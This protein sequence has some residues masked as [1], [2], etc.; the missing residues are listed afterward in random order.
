MI[1]NPA[2]TRLELSDRISI[3]AVAAALLVP[4]LVQ[5]WAA[6]AC[7]NIDINIRLFGN[8]D[9]EA[10]LV[11]SSPGANNALNLSFQ[12]GL[13]VLSAYINLTG[14]PYTAGGTDCPD[15]PSLDLGNDGSVEWR[16]NGTGYGR[17]GHQYLFSDGNLTFRAV[18]GPAGGSNYKMMIR[19][20]AGAQ[21]SYCSLLLTPSGFSGP[22]NVSFDVGNDSVPDWTNTAMAGAA[23]IAGIESVISAYIDS[24]ALSG[25]DAYGVQYVDVP[26]TV[27]CGSAATLTFSSLNL[28]YS[29]AIPTRNLAT[30]LDLLIPD[31]IGDQNVSVPLKVTSDSP[32]KLR[33]YDIRVRTQPPAHGPQL[34]DPLPAPDPSMDENSTL[35]FSVRPVDMYGNP[36]TL[37]WFID[38]A[39]V[40]GANG[41]SLVYRTN[42]TCAGRHMITVTAGNGLSEAQHSWWVTVRDVNRAPAVEAF[43]PESPASL[44]ENQA[45]TFNVSARDPD[46]DQLSYTWRL[47][48]REQPF[49]SS[50]FRY[51]PSYCSSG[52][53]DVDLLISD[54][55]GMSASVFWCVT[56][57]KS[58]VPPTMYS[59]APA[60]DP[61]IREG[62]SVRFSADASDLN[63]DPLSFEWV[64]DGFHV[65]DGKDFN[66]T[67]DYRSAG[68]K[69]IRAVVSD[70]EFTVYHSWNVTILDVNHPPRAVIDGPQEGAEYIDTDTIVVSG[71]RSYDPDRDPLNL[72]WTD[73]GVPLGSGP[74]V[75]LT[76][77]HGR[78]LFRLVV[79]DGRGAMDEAFVNITVRSIDLNITA[80]VKPANPVK[81]DRV[82]M[83]VR[84]LGQGDGTARNISLEFFVDGVPSGNRSIPRVEPGANLSEQFVW[85]AEPGQH[86]L[87]LTAGNTTLIMKMTVAEGGG[88]WF[89]S[90]AVLIGTVTISVGVATAYFLYLSWFEPKPRDKR[91]RARPRSTPLF[92]WGDTR[93]AA[94]DKI[95]LE[96]APYKDQPLEIQTTVPE[97]VTQQDLVRAQLSAKRWKLMDWH[98]RTRPQ[99]PPAAAEGPSLAPEAGGSP[100]T[101]AA[102]S[103]SSAAEAAAVADS[104]P[105]AEA[106]EA[107]RERE[108]P[109]APKKPR[110]RIKDIE[111]RIMALERKGADV[112]SVRRFLSLGR[113]FW[114]GGNTPKA[115]QYFEKAEGRLGELE[116]ATQATGIPLCPACGATVDPTWI[117][118]PECE[119]KLQ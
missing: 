4:L 78:H 21:L 55:G 64:V 67:T 38:S 68:I 102:F 24:A 51:Q 44:S 18:F 66:F 2:G 97:G 33:L 1:V 60:G 29:C 36:F 84:I 27:R 19:F 87:M 61:T 49:R 90:M 99:A 17:L 57:V 74:L 88:Q 34:L 63:G 85:T 26:V 23:T 54:P 76:L 41:S 79:D 113:S 22:L 119:G 7:A 109:S 5:P 71:M 35:N 77:A 25:A 100:L 13:R 95:R 117:V 37:Q 89:R 86:E 58:N 93:P 82:R 115:E 59:L 111:D 15:S 32:G 106:P 104:A 14:M 56:V 105:G 69:E 98:L 73:S 11:F 45:L 9:S 16:F 116:T 30:D 112:A 12:T 91:S 114:K 3:L 101:E 6:P 81:G 108:E 72:T 110:K 96:N 20:P 53:H 80:K 28:G 92:W 43:S 94:L 52:P 83:T 40:P 46:G 31:A 39:P 8:G 10:I 118:C 70:G 65:A 107:V 103:S 47:D 42:F 48:G 75:N 50:G 62:E